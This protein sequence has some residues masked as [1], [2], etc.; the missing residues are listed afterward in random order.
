MCTLWPQVEVQVWDP[1]G[2]V[3]EMVAWPAVLSWWQVVQRPWVFVG[4][5][6]PSG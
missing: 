6:G 5:E 3:F 1:S 4:V 2:L